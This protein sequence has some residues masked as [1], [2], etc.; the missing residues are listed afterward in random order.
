MVNG[1]TNRMM[2]MAFGAVIRHFLQQK[3]R[4]GSIRAVKAYIQG[5]KYARLAVMGLF[6]I[7]AVSAVL[8]AGI[9]LTIVGIV[10]LLPI[11]TTTMAWTILIIGLILTAV[12]GIG[13]AMGFKQK[14]WLELS[15]SHELMDTVLKPWPGVLPPN[16]LDS[17]KGPAGRV[18]PEDVQRDFESLQREQQA[19]RDYVAP[20][21]NTQPLQPS[22]NPS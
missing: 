9:V 10:G 15:R 1:F 14:R 8:V 13:L 12:T 7:G 17:F 19:S 3:I 2:N 18:K 16:P 11:E 22:F 4:G 21:P 20:I 6:G 5:V